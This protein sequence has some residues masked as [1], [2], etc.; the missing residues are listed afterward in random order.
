MAD[1]ADDAAMEIESLAHLTDVIAEVAAEVTE[2]PEIV[3]RKR[4]A[5]KRIPQ[6]AFCF[7]EWVFMMDSP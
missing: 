6:A 3:P 2:Q 7:P 5:A 4:I 1:P